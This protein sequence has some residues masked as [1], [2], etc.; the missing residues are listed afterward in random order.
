MKKLIKLLLFLII[1][2]CTNA[3]NKQ[4]FIATD[5]NNFWEAYDKINS[6]KDTTLQLGYINNLYINKA[7]PGL[8]SMM[9]I[10]NYTAKGYLEAIYNYPKFWESIK[11]NTLKVAKS[12]ALIE[13]DI[14]KLKNIYP[15]IKPSTIYFTIGIFRSGGTILGNQVLIGSELSLADHT[16]LI[17][18]LPD[19]RRP[20]YKENP[21]IDALPLLCTH[22]YIHTQQKE[23]VNNLLS[24]T[25]YEGVAEFISCLATNKK[26]DVPAIEYG[27]ANESRI[28]DQYVKD[29]FL[30]T[31]D[32]N[33]LYGENRNE[34]KIRDL[35][36][37]VGFEIAERYY[38]LSTDK[39][40]AIKELIELDYKNDNEVERIVDKTKL[41]PSSIKELYNNY[42]KSRPTVVGMV[43]LKNNSKDVK[44]GKKIITITF[45]EPLNGINTSVDFGP[46]GETAF[47]KMSPERTWSKD[48]KSWTF[49]VELHPN[50]E[51][52]IL[53]SNNFRKENGIRLKPYLI[54]FMTSD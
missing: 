17:S 34:F 54:S 38:N 45:S 35:G 15:N 36:Y 24:Y 13:N 39:T 37:Y 5:I 21:L 22:E 52:Q 2:I 10:R 42:D 47:P 48:N 53:I 20:F 19:W 11:P 44:P 41:L 6:T 40:K 23:V 49:E 43:P 7:S 29:L 46:L 25:L 31:N 28:I 18:E 51:Y 9:E 14:D 12:Y 4:A 30:F 16:T 33:W 3:Q 26:S 8:K 1:S 27:K 50:K 32:Y